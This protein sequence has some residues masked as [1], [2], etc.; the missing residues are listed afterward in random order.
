MS[1]QFK[2]QLTRLECVGEQVWE[3]GKDE[4]HLIGFGVSRKGRLFST[5]YRNLG[6]YHTGD[7]STSAVAP[8][9]MF[10]GELEDDGLE[11]LFYFWFIEEDGGG[12][13]SS[14]T[15]ID[16]TFRASFLENANLMG[17][18]KFPRECLTFLVFY[19]AILPLEITIQGAATAGRDDDVY[20]P[21]DILMR[22]EPKGPT[23]FNSS[24]EFTVRRSKRLGEY[25]A[26]F[27][28]SYRRNEILTAEA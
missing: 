13:R 16:E 9:T 12:V 26:T 25:L 17:Q 1:Y 28:Y 21:V 5:G 15:A 27:R 18:A 23:G 22:H 11:V 4:M 2:L 14:A 10:E 8:Q 3:W 19:K 24:G 7:V 6:S 20:L